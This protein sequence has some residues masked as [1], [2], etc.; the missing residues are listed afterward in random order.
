[1]QN[2]DILSL[3]LG[4]L[5]SLVVTYF[6]VGLFPSVEERQQKF[7]RRLKRGGGTIIPMSRFRRA[8][9]A[10]MLALFTAELFAGAFHGNLG[11]LAGISPHILFYAT[12]CLFLL[13]GNRDKKLF[14]NK[15]DPGA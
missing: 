15:Q 5:M 7:E 14:K 8:V 12:F 3:V 6:L 9:G 10:L 11:K 1:M 13:L 4:S 2:I